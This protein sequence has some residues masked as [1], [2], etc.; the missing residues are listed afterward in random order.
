V[1]E[2]NIWQ[3]RTLISVLQLMSMTKQSEQC[4]TEKERETEELK[5]GDL[6][7][8]ELLFSS[9]M[10]CHTPRPAS[11]FSQRLPF[12]K[13]AQIIRISPLLA[14]HGAVS[15]GE[16]QDRLLLKGF[17]YRRYRASCERAQ[18]AA[19]GTDYPRD[20]STE[21]QGRYE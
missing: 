18:T 19:G 20:Y 8:I 6:V 11:Y 5:S 17:R 2:N 16:R 7:G 21:Q 10:K 9:E 15:V 13:H 12:F 4:R 3:H 1:G 14:A